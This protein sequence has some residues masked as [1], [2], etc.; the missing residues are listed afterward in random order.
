[1]TTSST[2][3]ILL[4]SYG[5]L[6]DK[7]VQLANFGRELV[8]KPDAMLGYEQTWVEIKDRQVVATSGK[9]H[10]PIVRACNDASSEVVGTVFEITQEELEA[11]DRYEVS[12]YRRVSVR[13]KSG[14]D[15]W[16]YLGV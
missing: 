13:L 5:T 15:A 2:S 10:H 11:A 4:F 16:V 9:T 12:D 8:G 6:Q 1:M 7:T 3:A 14:V